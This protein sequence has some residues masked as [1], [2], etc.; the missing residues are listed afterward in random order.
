MNHSPHA[1]LEIRSRI[2]KPG[3]RKEERKLCRPFFVCR[4]LDFSLEK[5]KGYE[6]QMDIH[7][8]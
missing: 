1:N 5:Q 4:G 2:R 8:Q 7:K 3:G 6:H